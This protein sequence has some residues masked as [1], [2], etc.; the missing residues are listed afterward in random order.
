MRENRTV[1]FSFFI[2]KVIA[3]V[4][5]FIMVFGWSTVVNADG[6]QTAGDSLQVV[7]PAVSF[8]AT[9]GLRDKE[10]TCQW[11]KSLGSTIVVTYALK[12]SLNTKR[13]NGGDYSFPSGHTSAAFAGAGFIHQR[14]GWEYGVPAYALASFVG[15]SRIHSKNHY[16]YDVLGGAVIGIGSNLFFTN[17]YKKTTVAVTTVNKDVMLVIVATL[18]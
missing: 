12:Y 1:L 5:V 2:Q 6:V 18:D 7:I 4:I 14:Y 10:G 3:L 11:A 17:K 13:P 15:Y 16:W 8:V 9:L